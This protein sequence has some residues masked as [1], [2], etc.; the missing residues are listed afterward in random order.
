MTPA[1][2]ARRPARTVDGNPPR[3]VAPRHSL[4]GFAAAIQALG[5]SLAVVLLPAVVAFLASSGGAEQGGW[6]SSLTVG[7]RLWLLGHG[8]PVVTGKTT[9]TLVPLGLTMLLLF[10][11]FATAR[12]ASSA[13]VSAWLTGTLTY[14][15]GVLGVAVTASTS[16]WGLVI[17]PIGGGAVAA[18]G[19]GLGILAR[20][21]SPRITELAD[22]LLTRIPVAARLGVRGGAIAVGILVLLAAG[23]VGV[24]AVA[25]RA[26]SG[27]IVAGLAPGAL[28]GTILA[29]AQL[30]VLPNLVV[31]TTGWL[32]GPGFAVGADTQFAPGQVTDTAAGPL[33]P[34]PL[35]GALP[36]A[37]W[38]HGAA[39]WAPVLLVVVGAM[40]V[41]LLRRRAVQEPGEEF[42]TWGQVGFI[43]AAFGATVATLLGLL[44][45][46]AS[47]GV[48]SGRLAHIGG[49]WWAV[50]LLA[51]LECALGAAAAL[52][53]AR[54][55]IFARFRLRELPEDEPPSP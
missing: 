23:L 14:A 17:A 41:V 48:G 43:T 2:A 8:V 4:A 28:G 12:R 10:A 47:G 46:M 3:P 22:P 27:D 29:I 32:A 24:W 11:C 6:G 36:G 9:V 19:L 44:V 39:V 7:A 1:G 35:L 33:P 55:G 49:T 40:A 13:T 34:L 30:M 21:D 45:A 26:T 20:P 31:W 42:S 18:V 50:G 52:V 16:T 51:G 54:W 38:S 5:L 37:G 15:A 25:G 53:V